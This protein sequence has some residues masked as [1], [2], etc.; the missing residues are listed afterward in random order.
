[1]VGINRGLPLSVVPPDSLP[2]RV[3]G[4]PGRSRPAGFLDLDSVESLVA[5]A[6]AAAR[7]AV[8]HATTA[9]LRA[10][11]ETEPVF[12]P[13]RARASAERLG[14]RHVA[15]IALD[16]ARDATV[17]AARA[18]A[19]AAI[20]TS[21]GNGVARDM[22][23]R[24]V[25]EA[26]DAAGRAREAADEAARET[27]STPHGS[28]DVGAVGLLDGLRR[29]LRAQNAF[30]R[31]MSLYKQRQYR[32]ASAVFVEA[33]EIDPSFDEAWAVLGWSS[34]FAG[35]YS[36]AIAAFGAALQRQPTWE[37]LYDGLGWSRLRLGRLRLARDTF[38]T[39]LDLNADYAD[40]QMGLGEAYFRL[41]DYDRAQTAFKAAERRLRPVV[42]GD[43]EELRQIRARLA[44]TLYHLERFPEA[45][46]AFLL[47]LR[48]RPADPELHLGLG[49]AYLG[50][51]RKVDARAAFE[52]ALA[53]QPGYREAERGLA[54]AR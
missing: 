28:T 35:D 14:R 22:V 39:A 13:G 4:E 16:A 37:G 8:S 51:R 7:D 10:S 9:R 31:G 23:R 44:W 21:P 19:E 27:W 47:A 42:G 34:Y 49:W 2:D 50:L 41:G 52:R 32:Q 25:A 43:P 40:A 15:R 30:T 3:G 54:R 5:T 46:E 36:A 20:E 53:L 6:R 11:E 12:A 33:V 24:T 17:A 45:V 26:L 48:G 38:K 1:V 29:G 18:E